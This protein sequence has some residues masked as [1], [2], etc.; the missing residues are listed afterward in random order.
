M[1]GR[2]VTKYAAVKVRIADEIDKYLGVASWMRECLENEMHQALGVDPKDP[3]PPKFGINKEVV[4]KWKD[5]VAA[6][7]AL[8]DAK[9]RLDKNA[10]AMA[11]N[12]SPEEEKEAVRAYVR[13]L[14]PSERV[15]FLT[16]ELSWHNSAKS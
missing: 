5:C 14:P 7:N 6:F 9:V 1:D 13:S 11:D 12:M 8:S 16:S 15:V 3:K 10:K 2:L 4:A